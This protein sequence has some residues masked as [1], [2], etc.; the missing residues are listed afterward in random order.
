MQQGSLRLGHMARKH[1]PDTLGVF[2]RRGDGKTTLPKHRPGPRVAFGQSD[3]PTFDV[4]VC[5]GSLGLAQGGAAMRMHHQ[6]T[7]PLGRLGEQ[8]MRARRILPPPALDAR[9]N[10]LWTSQL[11]RWRLC[12]RSGAPRQ[13]QQARDGQ[14]KAD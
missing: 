11:G 7:A 14:A 2:G 9:G 4:F 10:A 12:G 6:H 1:A 5:P 3:R 8:I 13:K